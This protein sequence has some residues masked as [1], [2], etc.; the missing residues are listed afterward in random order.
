MLQGLRSSNITVVDPGRVPAKPK[1]PNVPVYLAI[2]LAVGVFGGATASLFADTVDDTIQGVEHLEY[3]HGIPLLGIMPFAKARKG[4]RELEAVASPASPF[5]EAVRGLRTSL[6]LSKGSEPPRVVLITSALSGEGKST[7]AKSLA[8]LVAK[9]GRRVLLVEADLR[10]P[11]MRKDLDFAGQ[12]GLSAILASNDAGEWGVG[13]AS[14]LDDV[15]NL[16]VLPAGPVPPDPAELLDSARMRRLVAAWRKQFDLV[17]LDGPPVLPVTD[18]LAL[19]GMA[20][21]TIMVARCGLTPRSS[22][23]RASSLIEEH[24]DRTRTRVVLNAVKP[25]SHAFFSYYGYAS[26][27]SYGGEKRESI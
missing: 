16:V 6:M 12:G 19:A 15:S 14:T 4:A 3:L 18:A 17:L 13:A 20:D 23:S 21:T 24:V 27:K 2:A 5:T 25:G 8:I 1:K 9:Q 11:R 26:S 10:R 7:L 22:F